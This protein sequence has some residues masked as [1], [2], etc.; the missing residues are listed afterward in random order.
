ML[1]QLPWTWSYSNANQQ[2]IE[3]QAQSSEKLNENQYIVPIDCL[4]NI[5]RYVNH[6]KAVI[7][8]LQKLWSILKALFGQRAW[9][10]ATVE[11]L[12][13]A[14]KFA[15]RTC[16][17][18]M[19]VIMGDLLHEVQMQYKIHNQS[20]FLYIASEVTNLFGSDP[21]YANYLGGLITELFGHTISLLKTIHGVW[22]W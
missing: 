19:A 11:R 6:P 18:S 7:D 13:R 10:S 17:K 15:V 2:V 20:Y 3:Q 12:C 14:C 9:D 5:F 16:Q 8:T 4:S 22:P 1:I 21:S